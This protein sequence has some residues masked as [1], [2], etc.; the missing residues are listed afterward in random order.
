MTKSSIPRTLCKKVGLVMFGIAIHICGVNAQNSVGIGT[1]SPNQKAVLELVSPNGDQGFLLP[2][3]TT[4]Q[5]TATSFTSTLSSAENGMIVYDSDLGQFFYWLDTQWVVGLGAFSDQAGGD[6]QGSYPNPIIRTDAVDSDK[7]LDG[8]IVGADLSNN[9]VGINKLDAQGNTS[10]VLAT[11]LSGN[12]Q[13]IPQSTFATT[14]LTNGEILIGDVTNIAQSSPVNGDLILANDGTATITPDAVSGAEIA[15][16][17]LTGNDIA[18]NAIGTSELADGSVTTDKILDGSIEGQDVADETITSS[19]ITNGTI[20]TEDIASGGTNK[21]LVTTTGGTV[22]WENIS[23]FET[24]NLPEGNIFLGDVSNNAAP[25]NARGNGRILIGDGTTVNSEG[26]TGDV[27]LSNSGDVQIISNAV[28]SNEI[29]DDAVDTN[30][31]DGEGNSNAVLT[32]DGSGNPQWS[33]QTYLDSGLPNGQIFIGDAGNVAQAQNVT[34]DINLSNTGDVQLNNNVVGTNEI[35]DNSITLDDIGPNAVADSEL[36]D[37]SVDAGAIQNDVV[38]A[39]KVDSEGN[40]DAVLT[41]DG[42]GNPQWES[43][44]ALNDADGD[45]NNEIQDLSI[46]GNT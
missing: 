7:I 34:G 4:T 23:L 40:V 46:S 44:A 13:W 15:D 12:T 43:K 2:R 19:K 22:F 41:T 1:A 6:L 27:T 39:A 16:E 10:S 5:R 21:V 29:E 18:A 36:A 28:G 38:S 33:P 9:S 8:S 42:S 24:S 3:L 11:D 31:L 17:T 35:N 14:D 20:Q 30:K 32:T 45:P 26:I 37:N 25:L